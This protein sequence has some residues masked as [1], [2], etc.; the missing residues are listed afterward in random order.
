METILRPLSNRLGGINTIP[1]RSAVELPRTRRSATGQ[2]R[3][4][5][6][7]CRLDVQQLDESDAGGERE[8]RGQRAHDVGKAEGFVA[9]VADVDR[10]VADHLAQAQRR[11]GGR[12]PQAS[13][14][15]PTATLQPVMAVEPLGKLV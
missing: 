12:P 15:F 6:T 2:V 3:F 14:M 9:L 7:V 5:T 4:G 10:V 1:F 13:Q 11:V 8:G